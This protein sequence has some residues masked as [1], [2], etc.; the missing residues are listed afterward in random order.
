LYVRFFLA[1]HTSPEVGHGLLNTKA[2][3]SHSDTPHSVGLLWTSDQSDVETF[4]SNHTTLT[5]VRYPSTGGIRTR[6]PRRQAARIYTLECMT[7][8]TDTISK[9]WGNLGLFQ[10]LFS[11]NTASRGCNHFKSS[12]T[13]SVGY[14]RMKYYLFRVIYGRQLKIEPRRT[15]RLTA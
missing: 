11:L 3:L 6:S 10:H 5:R 9:H 8:V 1:W 15:A 13:N 12:G 2:S 4:T 14:I 7:L